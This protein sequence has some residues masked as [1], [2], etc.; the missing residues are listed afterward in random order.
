MSTVF[1]N[2]QAVLIGMLLGVGGAIAF[3]ARFDRTSE[4][5]C[6]YRLLLTMVVVVIAAIVLGTV[7]S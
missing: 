6:F 2:P 3:V 1:L 7:S 5:G 4:S